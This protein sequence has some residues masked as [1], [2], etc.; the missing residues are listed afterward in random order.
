MKLLE[1]N[2]ANISMDF[3]TAISVILIALIY[4]VSALSGMFVPYTSENNYQ[5]LDSTVSVLLSPI[6]ENG[7][8]SAYSSSISG[9]KVAEQYVTHENKLNWYELSNTQAFRDLGFEKYQYYSQISP[10]DTTRFDIESAEQSAKNNVPELCNTDLVVRFKVLEYTERGVFYGKDLYGKVSPTKVIII[11]DKND[12]TSFENDISLTFRDFLPDETTNITKI[13]SF[14]IGT[15]FDNTSESVNPIIGVYP[16]LYVNGAKIEYDKKPIKI[17]IN[18][19]V[20]VVLNLTMLN[21]T[22]LPWRNGFVFQI[23]FDG[24]FVKD[25]KDGTTNYTSS[26]HEISEPYRISVWS[27]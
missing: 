26:I 18:D 8:T 23:N 9:E 15:S 22:K 14:K 17:D 20:K 10:L 3:L 1:D 5:H 11:F 2:S 7:F 16:D 27:W 24:I 21:N 13:K 12:T 19:T 25:I 6:N 4:T